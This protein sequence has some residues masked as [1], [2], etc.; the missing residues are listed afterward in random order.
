MNQDTGKLGELQAALARGGARW[1]AG[2]TPLTTLSD[3]EK[4]LRLGAT[5]PP[6]V[7]TLQAREQLAAANLQRAAPAAAAV[8]AMFDWRNVNGNNFVTDITD[9]G[10]CGSCVAFGTVATAE[11]MTRIGRSDA[12]LVV[13]Y[14]EAHLFYCYG[15]SQGYTCSTGW[16]PNGAMD[17]F[18]TGGVVDEA[19]F[20]YRAGDQA[21][22]LCADWQNRVTRISGWHEIQSVAEIKTWLSS[23][24]PLT[25]CFTVYDDFFAYTG[26][27]YKHVDQTVAGGHCVSCVGYSDADGCWI[28]KNSWGTG[29]G[30]TGFFRIAYGDCGI[31]ATMWAVEAVQTSGWI[32]GTRV[33]GLWAIDEDRNAWVFLEQ[34][35]WR[36]IANDSDN[37]LL[38]ILAQLT[39]AKAAQRKVDIYEEQGTVREVYVY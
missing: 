33:A 34:G 4:K 27:V 13:D 19:C 39:A 2:V 15:G 14:S 24:G 7:L 1:R 20:P 38:D 22:A 17:A 31:D 32:R 3:D 6:G 10:A 26:G 35:G 18:K 9:Q 12:N 28:C 25:T 36:K 5:P 8:P 37:V 16:W 21:C 11:A 23:K 30:E 29:W